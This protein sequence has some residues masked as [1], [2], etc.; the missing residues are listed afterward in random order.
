MNR[1]TFLA[2][3]GLAP[4]SPLAAKIPVPA[5]WYYEPTGEYLGYLAEGSR[6]NLMFGATEFGSSSPSKEE[7]RRLTT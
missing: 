6:T 1:R 3:I 4:A 5:R 2:F 7:M